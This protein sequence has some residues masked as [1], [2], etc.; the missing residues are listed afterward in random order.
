ENTPVSLQ[1]KWRHQ[2]QFAGYYAAQLKGFY[3]DKGLDVSIIEGSVHRP[4]VSRVLNGEADFGITGADILFDF[5]H[6][7]P[8]VI[9]SVIF[10]HSPYVFLTLKE[11]KIRFVSDLY[12]KRVMVSD[13]QGWV[14]LKSLFLKEGINIDSIEILR[15]SWSTKDLIAGK[16]DALSSYST[17]EP[18][19]LMQMGHVVSLVNPRDY[20]LDFYGDLIFTSESYARENHEIVESFN[21][22]TIKGW[23]YALANKEEI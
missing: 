16:I 18:Y 15:H 22:A 9:T 6:G 8:V 5:V 4:P 11:S 10:Q 13:D 19:Q 21:E 12:K 2:F 3:K 1:L 14:L 23:E 7:K 20:G 17:V